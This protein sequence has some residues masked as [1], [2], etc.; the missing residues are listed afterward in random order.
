MTSE[1]PT[2][3]DNGPPPSDPRQTIADFA[4]LHTKGARKQSHPGYSGD[5]VPEAAPAYMLELFRRLDQRDAVAAEA[6]NE[7]TALVRQMHEENMRIL[8]NIELLRQEVRSNQ[9]EN[10]SRHAVHERRLMDLEDWRSR[11]ESS[12]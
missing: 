12:R 7:V 4:E 6:L 2:A 1:P 10:Q 3:P 8:Q 5:D 11:T 9:T